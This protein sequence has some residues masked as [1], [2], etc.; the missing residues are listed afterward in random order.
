MSKS[1]FTFD[2]KSID[3]LQEA[4]EKKFP[5]AA[6][7]EG[8]EILKTAVI[9]LRD[10]IKAA[11]PIDS[12]DLRRSIYAKVLKDK[13]SEPMAADVRIK[14]GKKAA[15]KNRDGWY[16]RLHE[17]GTVKMEANPFVHPTIERFK[18][19]LR[20]YFEKYRDVLVNKFN[21]TDF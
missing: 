21:S 2:P 6:K 12:G 7:K 5:R 15:K 4:L 18:P 19:K 20:E 3:K 11:A 14:T 13:F 1:M 10:A 9:E 8:N 16:W 17:Y